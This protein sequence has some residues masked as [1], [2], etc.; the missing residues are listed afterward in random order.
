MQLDGEIGELFVEGAEQ[1]GEPVFAR[2]GTRADAQVPAEPPLHLLQVGVQRGVELHDVPG[3]TFE[4]APGTG[5]HG[6]PTAGTIEQA[7]V[8]PS[9]ELVELVGDPGL[10]HPDL[11]GGCGELS[12]RID[13]GEEGM[14]MGWAERNLQC[15]SRGRRQFFRPIGA[16]SGRV[17][18]GVV[19]HRS[20]VAHI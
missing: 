1:R 3:V 5:E 14:E 12:T 8:E 4:D 15:Q 16:F 2:T 17:W 7:H 9:L 19:S 13:D 6:R 20:I 18:G 11:S 10:A